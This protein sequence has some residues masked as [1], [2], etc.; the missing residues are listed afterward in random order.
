MRCRDLEPLV[1]PFVDG[2]AAPPDR[3]HVEAHLNA[4]PPCRARVDAERA[5]RE[6]VVSQRDELRAMAPAALR[7]RC[8]GLCRASQHIRRWVPISLAAA[9]GLIGAVMWAGTTDAGTPVLA[10]QLTLDHVKCFK[11][12]GQRVTGSPSALGAYWRERYGWPITVPGAVSDTDLRLSGVRRCGSSDGRTAHIM[13]T[14]KGRPLSLFVAQSD[15]DH[16]RT[17]RALHMFGDE[18]IVW[19][20]GDRT[21]VLVGDEPRGEMETL[22]AVFRK[23][24]SH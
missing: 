6:I 12:N 9:A 4:C 18:A 20:E 10:A 11:F 2:E 24:I 16:P 14:Y 1:V 13:Y 8:S 19:S 22:A 23:D 21:Y 7:T 15:P 3:A 5:A 17:P